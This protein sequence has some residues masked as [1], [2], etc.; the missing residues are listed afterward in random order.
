MISV[1]GTLYGTTAFGGSQ[2]SDLGDGTV[3]TIGAN[4]SETV[5]HR[6]TGTDGAHPNAGLIDV[7]GTLYGTT[8]G[9]GKSDYGT[10]F[11]V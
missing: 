4:G 9:G 1:N 11:G 5:R 6:F 8:S 10:V 7:N 2:A 3:F